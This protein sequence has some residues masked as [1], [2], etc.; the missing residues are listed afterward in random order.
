MGKRTR[1]RTDAELTD[2]MEGILCYEEGL[3]SLCL[4]S[5]FGGVY[6][7]APWLDV[8]EVFA[9]GGCITPNPSSVGVSFAWVA[10]NGEFPIAWSSGIIRTDVECERFNHME[11]YPH[12][13]FVLNGREAHTNNVSE[14]FALLAAVASLPK[15][16]SGKI[17]SDSSVTLGRFFSGW[18]HSNIPVSWEKLMRSYT[19]KLSGVTPV[20][21]GGHPYDSDFYRG[22]G[23]RKLPVHIMNV[24][25]DALC[26]RASR[27][28]LKYKEEILHGT[29]K[30]GV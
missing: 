26:G 8:K 28:Y 19:A 22:Y 3:E 25:C 5:K 13:H 29:S 20:L 9:D 10:T 17:Y 7:T 4:Q 6:R 30:R 23:D 27:A 1:K 2:L 12:S 14:Y 11:D 21:L 24:L 18:K 16:F 15:D